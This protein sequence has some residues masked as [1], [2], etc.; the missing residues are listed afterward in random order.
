MIYFKILFKRDS[1][2][3]ISREEEVA[4]SERKLISVDI[5]EKGAKGLKRPG[6]KPYT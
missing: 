3:P 6:S 5:R 2:S 4:R 1:V